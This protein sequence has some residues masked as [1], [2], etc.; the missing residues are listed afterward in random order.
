MA[1]SVTA[2]LRKLEHQS[3]IDDEIDLIDNFLSFIYDTFNLPRGGCVPQITHSTSSFV[4]IYEKRFIGVDPIHNTLVRLYANTATLPVRGIEKWNQ[5]MFEDT[6][7]SCN[8]TK[9]LGHL[10]MLGYLEYGKK[11]CCVFGDE[12][13]KQLVSEYVD[14]DPPIYEYNVVHTLPVWAN[15][16]ELF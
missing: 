6:T 12:G 13:L 8:H 14:P 4:P 5:V 11:T 15:N 1:G 7:F 9:L 3:L 16:V 2:F 10:S